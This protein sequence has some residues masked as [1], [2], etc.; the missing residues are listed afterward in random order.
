LLAIKATSGC[1][2]SD[3][4]RATLFPENGQTEARETLLSAIFGALIEEARL[5]KRLLDHADP[6]AIPN[7]RPVCA[8]GSRG[9]NEKRHRYAIGFTR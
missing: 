2:V 9:S 1:C 3:A 7:G 6:R 8:P 4:D 5:A